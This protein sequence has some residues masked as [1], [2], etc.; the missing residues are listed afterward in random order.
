MSV[1]SPR[2][3]ENDR[4]LQEACRR[5]ADTDS[6][7]ID[8]EFTRERT[9]SPKLGLIQVSDGEWHALIDPLAVGSLRPFLDLLE[10]TSILKILHAP[11]EDLE[12]FVNLSGKVCEPIF[13]TQTAAAFVGYGH[14]VSYQNLVRDL[15]GDTVPKLQTRT[16]WLRRPLSKDQKKYAILDVV[17]LHPMHEIL[18]R[19]LENLGRATWVE[20]EFRILERLTYDED[21]MQYYRRVKQAWRLTRRQLG[22]LQLLCAWREEEAF[23]RDCLRQGVAPD[24]ALVDL[25]KLQPTD[26]RDLRSLKRLHPREISR[27]GKHLVGIIRRGKGLPDAE[28]PPSIPSPVSDPALLARVDFLSSAI[29]IRAMEMN[30][31]H[32]VLAK[33]RTLEELVKAYMEGRDE[34][35][36]EG[37]RGWR[38]DVIGDY[39]LE[40]LAGRVAFRVNPDDREP[41]LESVMLDSGDT[42]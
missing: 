12:I 37:L 10:D 33:K 19:K 20:E 25:A 23:E 35:F 1:E 17:H 5:L 15:V 31:S 21:P 6:I 18:S 16:D 34:L 38:R 11:R 3:I 42:D 30:L 27:S 22:I 2:M 7:A 13:D 24:D 28:L 4:D 32:E 29:R 40:V 36:P 9:F 8:T 26:P 39:L 14:S 41:P